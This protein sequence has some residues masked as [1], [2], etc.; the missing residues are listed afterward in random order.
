MISQKCPD[1]F[2]NKRLLSLD[3]ETT[4]LNIFYNTIIE[5]GVVEVV[6][7]KVKTEYNKLFGG[8]HSSMFLVRKIHHIKD[9]ERFG[10][11]TF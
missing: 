11:K 6:D 8:G 2:K 5:L 7:G 3:I 4:G 1:I 9:S 10:K